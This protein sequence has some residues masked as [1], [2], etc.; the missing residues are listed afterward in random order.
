MDRRKDGEYREEHGGLLGHGDKINFTATRVREQRK[1]LKQQEEKKRNIIFE[2][3][4]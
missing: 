2:E 4:E 1:S 3:Q